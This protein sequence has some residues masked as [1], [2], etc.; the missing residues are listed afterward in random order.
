MLEFY[1]A[2]RH[3]LSSMVLVS[4][5]DTEGAS[6]L[7]PRTVSVITVA[8]P[9]PNFSPLR[10]AVL[11]GGWGITMPDRQRGNMPIPTLQLYGS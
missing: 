5:V 11:A 4:G 7:G 6:V 8:P 3:A 9:T 10:F 2:F 1:P